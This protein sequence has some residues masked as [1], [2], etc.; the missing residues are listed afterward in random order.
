M[1]F[2]KELQLVLNKHKY[3]IAAIDGDL[4]ITYEEL[5]KKICEFHHYFYSHNIH[6]QKIL[7]VMDKSLEYYITFMALLASSNT[8][9]PIDATTTPSERIKY[10]IE[11]SESV[12]GI[13]NNG[14]LD[15]QKINV[16]QYNKVLGNIGDFP[17]NKKYEEAYMVYTSGTTGN[18]KGVLLSYAGILNVILD[19][20]EILQLK[21][22]K[23]YWFNSLNFDAS[24]SDILC[25]VFSGSTLFINDKV[26]M[27]TSNFKSYINDNK[28]TYIDIPPAYLALIAPSD[29]K[30]VKKLLIGG[31]VSSI[32]KIKEFVS[33]G[34]KVL[35]VYGPTEATICS[36]FILCDSEFESNNIGHPIKGIKYEVTDQGELIIIGENL[37]LC[38]F[39][40]DEKHNERFKSGKYYTG[41]I[42]TFENGNYYFK[43]RIDRQT[44]INGQL[45]CPEEIEK[46][47]TNLKDIK[48]CIIKIENKKIH[49][50]IDGN[51][52]I[53]IIKQ[54]IKKSLP[55]YM[56]PH[57]FLHHKHKENINGKKEIA[58]DNENKYLIFLKN[59]LSD[60]TLKLADFD[61]TI[62]DLG[63]D[64]LNVIEFQ[65]FLEENDINVDY[66]ELI[67]TSVYKLI[68]KSFTISKNKNTNELLKF[69]PSVSTSKNTASIKTKTLLITGAT[70]MLGSEILNSLKLKYKKIYAISRSKVI[71]RNPYITWI[72]A[73]ISNE[74][75]GLIKSE[76]ERLI[77]EV[78]TVIHCAANVNNLLTFH[79]LYKD[80]VL[81]T[82][83]IIDFCNQGIKKKLHYSSTLS[84]IISKYEDNN[85]IIDPSNLIPNNT[86]H[87]LTGYAQSKW[88]SEYMVS[89]YCP[90]ASVYRY[91]LLIPKS[92]KLKN[93]HYLTKLTDFI[94][95]YS[96]LPIEYKETSFD[97]SVINNHILNLSKSSGIYNKST[98]K[99]VT[100]EKYSQKFSNVRWISLEEWNERYSQFLVSKLWTKGS[101]Y[102]F[103]T[104]DIDKF[105]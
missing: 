15:D 85:K 90:S 28:I 5:Y 13:A 97:Y 96:E 69:M 65:M 23:V 75:M 26:K 16:I 35:N 53:D 27:E 46:V 19:Q 11:N 84:V 8:P 98:N 87:L 93:S 56:V 83:M 44:K 14:V 24:I 72:Q 52:S 47:I 64:S 51:F 39:N 99:F 70:G 32:T 45:V 29:I 71:K 74:N 48:S 17:L 103:E 55:Q 89:K 9:V 33:A 30:S 10:I 43:G 63:A 21:N 59:I 79:D 38:Y 104:T 4:S 49:A 73:D 42:V 66:E 81:S 91:G 18:P 12:Y 86:T 101:V 100:L 22:E 95:E 68:N 94:K 92:E 54:Q 78:D 3:K 7:I 88:L 31:E 20:V 77:H 50:Y 40:V 41:D 82:K 25:T 61:K 60:K 1:N 37:A 102:F 58:I 36:S 80:N 6:G 34:I 76:Y 62:S 57:Y 105:S 2:N 67:K